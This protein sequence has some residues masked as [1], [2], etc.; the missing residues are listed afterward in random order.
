MADTMFDRFLKPGCILKSDQ[1]CARCGN[2][3]VRVRWQ[4]CRNGVGRHIRA[5]CAR[6][7]RYIKF[8]SQTPANGAAADYA[9]EGGKS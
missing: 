4:T 1:V 5:D 3:T 7:G 2:N 9:E 8:L 6:C